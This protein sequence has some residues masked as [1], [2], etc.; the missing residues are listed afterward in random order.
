[1]Q[2]LAVHIHFDNL[3][4]IVHHEKRNKSC[5]SPSNWIFKSC[6]K[7]NIN[8]LPEY[9]WDVSCCSRMIMLTVAH[10]I[11]FLNF[12]GQLKKI[13]SSEAPIAES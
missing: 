11:Y 7:I 9:Q 8:S 6:I 3:A 2:S 13:G 5:I 12:L 1:M 4:E 10:D